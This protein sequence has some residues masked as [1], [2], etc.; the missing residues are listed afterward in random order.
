MAFS[1]LTSIISC[2]LL[3]SYNYHRTI[4]LYAGVWTV[5]LSLT[6]A[7]S[8][9]SAEVSFMWA[10]SPSSS[11]STA[12]G[13]D[14]DLFIRVPADFPS[15][16]VCLPAKLFNGSEIDFVVP[17]LFAALMVASS[18]SV[19]RFVGLCVPNNLNH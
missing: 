3:N 4:L 11:F 18:A 15:N 6:V 14:S 8:A 16:V 2:H 5:L 10:I 1:F 12:C 17:P 7:I 13:V 9:M 19:V